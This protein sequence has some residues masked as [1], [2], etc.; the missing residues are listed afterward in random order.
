M[1]LRAVRTLIGASSGPA[2]RTRIGWISPRITQSRARKIVSNILLTVLS[3]RRS[4]PARQVS[5]DRNFFAPFR[6]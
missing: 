4:V 3:Q 1:L 6:K 2:D 5:S